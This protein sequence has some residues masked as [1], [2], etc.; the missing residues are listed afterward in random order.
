LRVA[1]LETYVLNTPLGWAAAER[2]GVVSRIVDPA[3]CVIEGRDHVSACFVVLR[4]PA[5]YGD[6]GGRVSRLWPGDVLTAAEARAAGSGLR[7]AVL[8]GD[9]AELPAN[10]G[11]VDAWAV[12]RERAERAER[13]LGICVALEPADEDWSDE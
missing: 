3:D 6:E 10:R 5:D 2:D 12:A 8:R 9:L 1:Q 11:L 4:G 7:A 13:W